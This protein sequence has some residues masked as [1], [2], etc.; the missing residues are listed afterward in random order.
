MA[1]PPCPAKPALPSVLLA[2]AS[3]LLRLGLRSLLREFLLA[4]EAEDAG[5]LLSLARERNASGIIVDTR[6]LPEPEESYV[7]R[8]HEFRPCAR[9]LALDPALSATV[10]PDPRCSSRLLRLPMDVASAQL[11]RFI[12]SD[13]A[14]GDEPASGDSLHAVSPA[15]RPELDSE[16][17]HAAYQ[18]LS[19][20]ER[21][22]MA[23][24]LQG[25]TSARIAETLYLSPRT[26]ESHRTAI[27]RKLR[28]DGQR[29][30]FLCGLRLGLVDQGVSVVAS[31]SPA[32]SHHP[33][34]KAVS[35]RRP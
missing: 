24:A 18:R 26:V 21:E 12:R 35:T 3:E 31:A 7:R 22:V 33:N 25:W 9:I 5:T 20:R 16:W 23:L 34:L 4:G 30:L 19:P 29:D 10:L 6:L 27:R 15:V 28:L 32:G 17:L 11:L 14:A 1:I 8:L 2:S 13:T